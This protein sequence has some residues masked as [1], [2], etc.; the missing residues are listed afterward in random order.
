MQQ[1]IYFPEQVGNLRKPQYTHP[2]LLTI[3]IPGR[4]DL[5]L[6]TP[7]HPHASILGLGKKSASRVCKYEQVYS[8]LLQELI[9]RQFAPLYLDVLETDSKYAS[10]FSPASALQLGRVLVC[11]MREKGD[12]TIS[13]VDL[14]SHLPIG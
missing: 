7:S 2:A 12:T 6:L 1:G 10:F 13:D 11:A 9:S 14:A 5:H 3:D 8:N 4:T